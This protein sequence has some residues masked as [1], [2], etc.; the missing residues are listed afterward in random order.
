MDANEARSSLLESVVREYIASEVQTLL[1]RQ[2]FVD[3]LPGFILPDA[4]S[5]ARRS[6]LGERLREIAQLEVN[7]GA[8]S[9][10][11]EP[12]EIER[13]ENPPT[14]RGFRYK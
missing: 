6:Q 10:P 2:D 13:V 9:R 1:K 12:I 4:G 8:F 11:H 14:W 5:Q 7:S 3:A